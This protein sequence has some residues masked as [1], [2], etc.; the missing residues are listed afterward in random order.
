M[1]GWSLDYV[2][3]VTDSMGHAF[4]HRWWGWMNCWEI[5]CKL[6]ELPICVVGETARMAK[7]KD[8]I[9]RGEQN[10]KASFDWSQSM[11]R[12]GNGN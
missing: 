1:A 10:I 6:W 11:G 8:Y 12:M 3:N 5:S 4:W 2:S 7:C 9:E